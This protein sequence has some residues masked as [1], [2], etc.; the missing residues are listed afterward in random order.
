MAAG[1]ALGGTGTASYLARWVTATTFTTSIVYDDGTNIGIG[2]LPS[3]SY[4]VEVNGKLKST[5]INETSDLRFKKN[6]FT[7]DNALNKVLSLRGVNYEWRV[8]EFKDKNF[9]SAP[10]IGLIAQ[11]VE[12]II[13]QVVSTDSA[14]YKSVEYSKLVALLIEAIKEQQKKIE[15]LT[16]EN[17]T[18][19]NNSSATNNEINT[20]KA[21]VK[22][23]HDAIDV[24]LKENL[25]LKAGQK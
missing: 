17:Q 8:N 12:K 19:K 22:N 24:L 10:Q 14:G 6:I 9:D 23:M 7:I 25:S 3:G 2:A 18:L 5:G 1:T 11:E 16:A 21:D 13:P 15:A 4:K 20:L